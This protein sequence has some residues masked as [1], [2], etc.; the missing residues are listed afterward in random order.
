MGHKTDLT[1][2]GWVRENPEKLGFFMEWMTA[3]REG[4]PIWLDEFP[5]TEETKGF[6]DQSARYSWM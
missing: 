3:Q 6:K 1:V 4:M 5:M 2:F